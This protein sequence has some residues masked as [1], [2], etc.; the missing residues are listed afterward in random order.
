M[1]ALI[2]SLIAIFTLTLTHATEPF[3]GL[4]ID[5]NGKPIK[6]AKVYVNNPKHYAKSDKEGK[7]GL[8]DVKSTDT[9]HV[10]VNKMTYEIPVNGSKGMRITVGEISATGT[11]DEELIK[12]GTGYVKKREYLGPRSA[13]THEQLVATGQTD[14]IQA[15]RGLVAGVR[16]V[17]ND[18]GDKNELNGPNLS[19]RNSMS[20][21]APTNPL[22]VVDGSESQIPPSLT[23]MEVES[24]EILK[25]GAGYGSRGANGVI[26][27]TLKNK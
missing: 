20:F 22:W 6:D 2:L 23:V 26:I 10:K 16:V 12:M 5:F 24:V 8:T 21:S 3:N 14:L 11:E 25:D 15:M 4:L 18:Y 27:V 13:V 19:I 1:R 17:N 9:L 7:F